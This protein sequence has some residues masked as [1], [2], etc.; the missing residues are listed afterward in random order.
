MFGLYNIQNLVLN[1]LPLLLPAGSLKKV[2]TFGIIFIMLSFNAFYML[3]RFRYVQPL[4]YITG[5]ISR[6][7]YIQKYRP[8]YATIQYANRNLNEN[9][10]IFAPHFSRR[11]YYSEIEIEFS[12][13]MLQEFA[14]ESDNARELAKKLKGMGFT[15]LLV[16]FSVFNYLVKKY[17]IHDK[18]VLKD[19]FG[20]Y[21]VT[22]FAKN[23]FG[24]LRVLGSP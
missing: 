22:E 11:G 20:T 13:T 10:K 2:I 17:P 19:F 15:H 12:R 14:S 18:I 1:R 4:A 16:N 5:E 9:A 24:L 21:T 23:G 3:N 7:A 8:E 6:D